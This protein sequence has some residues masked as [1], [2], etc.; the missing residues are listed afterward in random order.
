MLVGCPQLEVKCGIVTGAASATIYSA[1]IT[2]VD[3][4]FVVTAAGN[5]ASFNVN[6]LTFND[7]CTW[8]GKGIKSPP[9]F[10]MNKG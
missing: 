6:A 1:P 3:T 4:A 2:D 10:R 5:A 9:F 7:K 8:V